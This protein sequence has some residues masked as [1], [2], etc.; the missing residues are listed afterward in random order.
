MKKILIV[1]LLSAGAYAGNLFS[2]IS[3]MGMEEVK[4]NSYTID[5][6]GI[7]PRVYQFNP[8]DNKDYLCVIVFPNSDGEHTAAVPAM[9]CFKVK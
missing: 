3:G 5:T 2:T 6:V 8:K 7:N 4:T 1:S 9:Q